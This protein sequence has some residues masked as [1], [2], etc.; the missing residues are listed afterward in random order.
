VVKKS[1]LWLDWNS[2]LIWNAYKVRVLW[3]KLDLDNESCMKYIRLAAFLL[4]NIFFNIL[5]NT[6]NTINDLLTRLNTWFL[7]LSWLLFLSYFFT[8][9]L[10]H[11][12]ISLNTLEILSCVVLI[13]HF[14]A[15]FLTKVPLI[16]TIVASSHCLNQWFCARSID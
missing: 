4:R 13:L 5:Y 1:R 12:L 7:K 9:K 11:S 10:S 3:G 2:L 14:N 6:I 16:F 8:I 15:A